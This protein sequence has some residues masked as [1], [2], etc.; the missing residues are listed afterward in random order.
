MSPNPLEMAE[1]LPI[2]RLSCWPHCAGKFQ[3][4]TS[5]FEWLCIVTLWIPL[6]TIYSQNN[7]ISGAPC[8]HWQMIRNERMNECKIITSLL[9]SL[10]HP[11]L[12]LPE[13]RPA[14]V[15]HPVLEHRHLT[16]RGR[17][18]HRRGWESSAEP[19]WFRSHR[20]E[21]HPARQVALRRRPGVDLGGGAA[22][23][24]AVPVRRR[25]RGVALQHLLGHLEPPATLMEFRHSMSRPYW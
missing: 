16:A 6:E 9:F 8:R 17:K 19:R 24:A 7:K 25:R 3:K 22:P 12:L 18:V 10:S 2:G 20:L 11:G 15:Q 23:L 14:V 21:G 13:V 1:W 5:L 4:R